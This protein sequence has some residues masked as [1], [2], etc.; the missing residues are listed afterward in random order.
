MNSLL[1]LTSCESSHAELQSLRTELNKD[2]IRGNRF[3]FTFALHITYI[4]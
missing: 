1:W 3:G 2:N 4:F